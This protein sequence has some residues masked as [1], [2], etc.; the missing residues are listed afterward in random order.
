MKQQAYEAT[1]RFF[2]RT[3]HMRL[4]LERIPDPSNPVS[5]GFED[6]YV[7]AVDL[8]L[9]LDMDEQLD[10]SYAQNVVDEDCFAFL[11]EH[12]TTGGA[13]VDV[14][15][16]QGI[17]SCLVL[18]ESADVRVVA[19]EPDPYSTAKIRRNV[20]IN[21][22]DASRLNLFEVAAG[23]TE[24][25]RELM[26]NVAG[27]RAGSSLVVDQRQWTQRD[28]NVTISVKCRPLL[29][30]LADSDVTAVSVMKLDI[31]GFEFPVLEAFFRDAPV[32]LYPKAM[33]VEAFGH[34]IPL[35]GGSTVELL[36]RR[37][38]RLANHDSYNYFFV[39]PASL[40]K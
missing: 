20:E 24:E 2:E 10:R 7:P 35:V 28:D 19:I 17:Y 27:N 1:Q 5:L 3:L 40:S 30:L 9:H 6:H 22:L 38:Y 32:E 37:G 11:R 23:A 25:E 34:C 13:F 4:H 18:H 8:T 26:L 12:L 36:I 21:S 29:D 31:E 14:G 16:N 33:I 15:A 39:W